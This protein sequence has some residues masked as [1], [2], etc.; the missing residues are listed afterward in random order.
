MGSICSA[1]S[2]AQTQDLNFVSTKD[3]GYQLKLV[4][5]LDEKEIYNKLL[6]LQ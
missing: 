3:S 6:Q 5:T 1:G 4:C 2:V